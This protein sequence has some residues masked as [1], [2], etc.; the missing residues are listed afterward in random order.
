MLATQSDATGSL[1]RIVSGVILHAIRILRLAFE[2]LY[3]LGPSCERMQ[4]LHNPPWLMLDAI[5]LF[6]SLTNPGV[7]IP[8]ENQYCS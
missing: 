2:S 5:G 7:Q 6:A 8:S 3:I 1:R 4:L